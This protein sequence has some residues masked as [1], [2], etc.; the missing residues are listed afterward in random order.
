MMMMMVYVTITT[1]SSHLLASF[2]S[3]VSF[4]L[5]NLLAT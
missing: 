4:L 1:Y 5:R 3:V 2:L